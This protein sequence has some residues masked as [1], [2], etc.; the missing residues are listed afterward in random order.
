MFTDSLSNSASV[1]YSSTQQT[2]GNTQQLFTMSIPLP[3]YYGPVTNQ[4]P[5]TR[6]GTTSGSLLTA[7]A[8]RIFFNKSNSAPPKNPVNVPCKQFSKPLA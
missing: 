7:D 2:N 5:T 4:T 1:P 3:G 8:Y 6:P